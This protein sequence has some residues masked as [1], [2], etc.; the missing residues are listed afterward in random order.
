MAERSLADS[1]ARIACFDWIGLRSFGLATTPVICHPFDDTIS[2]GLS[3][4]TPCRQVLRTNRQ[5][6]EAA[7]RLGTQDKTS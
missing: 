7:S 3:A 4:N 2:S 5:W 6:A 1:S